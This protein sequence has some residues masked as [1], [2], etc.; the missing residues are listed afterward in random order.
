MALRD[1]PYI[2]LYVQDLLTDEKLV[3]CSAESHGIYFRLM[4]ILHKQNEYGKLCL[5]QKYKQNR[6]KYFCFAS[7]LV[8]QMPFE[9][10]QIQRSLEE[11]SAEGVI[12][13]EDEFLYQKRMVKDG[14]ISVTRSK[15]GKKGGSNVTKQYGKKGYLYLMSD[16]YNKTKIGISVNPQN[17]LYRIRSDN[18]LS[19]LFDIKKTIKVNDMGKSEDFAQDFFKDY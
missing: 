16:G 19:K 1:Q 11:L 10:K 17:R 4:C 14:E 5:K 7:M 13:I 15:S 9:A 12:V 8:K 6:S 18:K 3:E 2:P